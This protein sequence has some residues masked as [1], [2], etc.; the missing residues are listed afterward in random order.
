MSD[1]LEPFLLSL[2]PMLSRDPAFDKEVNEPRILVLVKV[3]MSKTVIH[4]IMMVFAREAVK[5]SIYYDLDRDVREPSWSLGWAL[6]VKPSFTSSSP[7]TIMIVNH[8]VEI[9]RS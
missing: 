8:K 7:L 3:I 6:T 1:T 4:N 5:K 2:P 9:W